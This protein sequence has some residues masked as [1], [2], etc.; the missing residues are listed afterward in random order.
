MF[1]RTAKTAMKTTQCPRTQGIALFAGT[2][3]TNQR[4]K[5]LSFTTYH[6]IIR[7]ADG[8]IMEQN[9][10]ESLLS[11]L[12]TYPDNY[13]EKV[14]FEVPDPTPDCDTC[15]S[16]VPCKMDCMDPVTDNRSE[17][18]D[19][20]TRVIE[21]IKAR[22]QLGINKYGKTVA[23]NPLGLYQWVKHFQEEILDAAVYITRA[24][25]EMEKG[26]SAMQYAEC[27]QKAIE[28]HCRGK[29]V[30]EDPKKCPYHAELLNKELSRK[31]EEEPVAGS[32]KPIEKPNKPGFWTDGL[33]VIRVFEYH[34]SL[35]YH[36]FNYQGWR[37]VDTGMVNGEWV[38]IDI[39][40]I[41]WGNDAKDS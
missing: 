18:P 13:A 17:L 37:T 28:M 24:M 7:K 29:E 11:P 26:Q 23:Q 40:A 2:M 5:E 30:D 34:D 1:G 6:A 4:S 9:K 35:C 25:Q 8:Q 36:D 39:K 19:T 27:L 41:R 22:Q 33:T 20:E 21:E 3:L 31:T 12:N 32:T 15:E 10:E 38:E 16:A 14:E